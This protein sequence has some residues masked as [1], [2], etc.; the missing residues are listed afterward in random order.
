ML[1]IIIICFF[2]IYG[3]LY[4]IFAVR[5][6]KPIKTISFFA[7][8]GIVGL[9]AVNITSKFSGVYIPVNVYTLGSSA[10][11]GLPGTISLLLLK[12]MFI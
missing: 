9:A 3:F 6:N 11:F 1:K 10:F 4:L 8:L 12:M 2:V 7:F 5:T